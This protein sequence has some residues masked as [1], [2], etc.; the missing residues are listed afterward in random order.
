M[1]EK[2]REIARFNERITIQKNAVVSDRLQNR[3]NAWKDYYSCYAYA[4]TYQFDEEQPKETIN[5]EQTVSFE[6]RWC[7][8]LRKIDSIHYRIVFNGD[9][10]NIIS[11]DMMNYQRRI[12]RIRSRLEKQGVKA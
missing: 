10:Y 8:E 11:I 7:Q 2:R 9:T 3:M 12:I 1:D 4:S 5:P 6:V